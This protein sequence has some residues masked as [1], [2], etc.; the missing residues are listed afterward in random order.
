MF[1][2]I[3]LLLIGFLLLIVGGE[4]LVRGAVDVAEKMGV[5]PL[6]IGITLVGLGTSMPELATAVQASNAGVPGIAIGGF[7]G[8]NI[9]NIFLIVG[10]SSL[11]APLIVSTKVLRGD[12]PVVLGVAILFACVSAYLPLDPVVGA[13]FLILLTAYLVYAYVREARAFSGEHI[14]AHEAAET[15]KS[16]SEAA[17][18]GADNHHTWRTR[19]GTLMP[20]IML[21]GGMA[22][23]IYGGKIVI[24]SAVQL[25]RLLHVSETVIGLTIVAVGTSLPELVTSVIAALR[26]HSEVAVGNIMGS[27][28]YNILGIGGVVGI[29]APTDVPKQIIFYDN[30]VMIFATVAL[31]ALALLGKGQIVRSAGVVLLAG[32][33]TYI[34]SIW[35][36]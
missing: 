17:T 36:H 27:N 21:I 8:S 1:I 9:S 14:A 4:L 26:R 24:D 3:V 7:V 33:I 19:L 32:Y 29:L 23:I 28:I 11:V 31:F 16:R 20:A 34:W 18:L 6:L 5:S 25:A 15:Q 30:F 13:C 35:P 10:L 22:T 12:G 2:D